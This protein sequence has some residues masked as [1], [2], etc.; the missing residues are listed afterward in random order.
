MR[1]EATRAKR[2]NGFSLI[3]LMV[4][5]AI[6]AILASIAYPSYSEYLVKTRRAAGT[7]CLLEQA[8]FMERYYSTNMGYT[9]AALPA[10]ACT[11]DLV[12]HYAFAFSVGPTATA[13]TVAATPKGTQL[14]QDTSC[15]TLSITQTGKKEASG[16]GSS[17]W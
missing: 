5:V 12:D 1:T 8:Q 13:F 3:E 11:S 9:G 14:S 10:T 7:S 2:S 6:I 15:G 4:V 17:C 16:G